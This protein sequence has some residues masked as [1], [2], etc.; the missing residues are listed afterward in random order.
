MF[1]NVGAIFIF[2]SGSTAADLWAHGWRYIDGEGERGTGHV[3]NRLW[4]PEDLLDGSEILFTR[5]WLQYEDLCASSFLIATESG[6]SNNDTGDDVAAI[7]ASLKRG[8][9]TRQ[10]VYF[11]AG[12]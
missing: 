5:L 6:S 8:A 7:N 1:K 11:P 12:I 4:K 9:G 10:V 3:E 2:D